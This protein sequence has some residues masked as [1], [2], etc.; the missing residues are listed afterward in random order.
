MSKIG[1]WIIEQEQSGDIYYDE[2]EQRYVKTRGCSDAI[3]L[4]NEAGVSA[5]EHNGDAQTNASGQKL[6]PH[7]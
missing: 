2:R 3:G 6:L 1:Q 4:P 7:D 5:A